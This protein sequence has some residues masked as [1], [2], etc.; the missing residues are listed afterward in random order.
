MSRFEL[1]SITAACSL[2]RSLTRAAAW[3]EATCLPPNTV[4]EFVVRGPVVTK[5][6]FHRPEATRLAK[7]HDP[8]TG[9][10]LHRMGDV[11]YLDDKGRI[12]FCGRKS[13]R[14]GAKFT[15]PCEGV[16]NAHPAVL[17]T[18]HVG[19]PEPVLCVEI[20]PALARRQRPDRDSASLKVFLAALAIGLLLR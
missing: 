13:H 4:G 12:W 11:G 5:E 17:R 2:T 10:V 16:F 3:D 19:V 14:V 1:A 9:D 7:I 20:D 18:A 8:A 6:Y 15:I